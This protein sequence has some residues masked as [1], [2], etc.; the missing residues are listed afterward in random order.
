MIV[1]VEVPVIRGGWLIQCIDSV[2]QQTSSNWVLSLRWD[3]GDELSRKILEN[4]KTLHSPQIEVHFG[5]RLGIARA[6]QF[7]TDSSH[8][9]LILPL[10]DDDVLEPTAVA[11]FLKVATEQPWAG[12]LRA[13]RGFIDDQGDPIEMDD[14][15]PF[16]R[17]H[18]F[19][20]ATLDIANHTHPYAIRRDV[21]ARAGGWQGFEDY[22]YFGEDCNCFATIEELAEVELMDEILYRYR[23][24]GSRTSLRFPQPSANELWRRIA[25]EA[26]RR[27]AVP[28]RR[29]NE[30]PPFQYAVTRSSRPT[31]ADIDAVIPFW[32][33]DEREV[34]YGPARPSDSVVPGQFVLRADTRFSQICNPPIEAFHRL[35]LALS[36]PG[37][38]EGVLL[39]A[40]FRTPSSFSPSCILRHD[41]RT[42]GLYTFE[43]VSLQAPQERSGEEPLGR[44]E[45]TF[46][47]SVSCR[48]L[49]ILH[50]VNHEGRESAL[51]RFFVR[52]AGH[53]RRGLG[54][55]IDSL[56]RSGVERSSLHIIEKRQASSLNR[57]QAFRQCSK[58]WICFMDDDVELHDANTL[59]RMLEAMTQTGASLCGPRLLNSSGRLY[60]GVPFMNPLTL[61]ARVGGMGDVDDGQHNTLGIV[62]WLPST[63]L[64]LHRSVML[65]TGGFD[66]LYLGSQHEDADF[67]LRARARGFSCCYNGEMAATHYNELRNARFSRNANY[68]RTRWQ[69]RPDL[70]LPEPGVKWAAPCDPC[71]ADSAILEVL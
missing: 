11:R 57:N 17:R 55:S 38:I 33:S 71:T 39:V 19:R 65:A 68:F 56:L 37:P 12:L 60:S 24:H 27:R 45:I 9:E 41:L 35:E 5:S 32:E 18:Y 50:T 16:E 46:Q 54:R 63:V 3:E 2:L 8:G 30:A 70:F 43:F 67:S 6:R 28:A 23:I 31:V 22:E 7:L 49:V 14:W 62:P 26:L 13:R 1:S 42:T 21:F 48:E 58:T 51:I 69:N 15:F 59:A 52:D 20:G 4:M 36:A 44:L 47:P 40:F 10:D 29:I 64:L 66:E 34:I 61:E 25:D 53:C